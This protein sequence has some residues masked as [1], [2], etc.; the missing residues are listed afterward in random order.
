MAENPRKS[1][2]AFVVSG[3]R[4]YAQR[5]ESI[6]I[7]LK[8]CTRCK[9]RKRRCDGQRPACGA[10]ATHNVDCSYP[11]ARRLRG[12]GKRGPFAVKESQGTSTPPEECSAVA[13]TECSGRIAEGM[14]SAGLPDGLLPQS[15]DHSLKKIQNSVNQGSNQAG[16]RFTPLLP[17]E[18]ATVM[19]PKCFNSL[20]EGRKVLELEEFMPHLSTQYEASTTGPLVEYSRWA[21]VN[22]VMGLAGKFMVAPGSESVLENIHMA[23]YQ[24]AAMVLHRLILRTPSLLTVQAL[25]AMALY[26]KGIPDERSFIMLVTC[27]SKQLEMMEQNRT[28]VDER[29]DSM[30]RLRSFG[31]VRSLTRRLTSE[32]EGKS[33]FP[34]AFQ[35]G[36]PDKH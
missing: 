8:A 28:A 17:Y 3:Y 35:I 29:S 34:R 26:A 7:L 33:P 23:Y 13:T 11:A 6:F 24:N 15:F 22:A 12:L 25:L 27:A 5:C 9:A 30:Q 10:C 36:R 31:L 18:I 20:M 1:S 19:I 4:K 2:Q 21:L 32:I 16:E 14:R